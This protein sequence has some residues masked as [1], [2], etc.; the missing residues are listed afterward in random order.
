MY[1]EEELKNIRRR[2]GEFKLKVKSQ[3]LKVMTRIIKKYLKIFWLFARI[4]FINQIVTHRSNFF[5]AILGKI[6][7][8]AIILIFFQAIYFNT[9]KIA[10]WEYKHIILLI[11]TYLTIETLTITTFHRNL[12]YYFPDSLKKGI[13][14]FVLIKPINPLFHISFRVV[15]LMDI[16]GSIFI[17]GLWIWFFFRFNPSISSGQVLQFS[18]LNVF[19]YFCLLI[20]AVIFIFS[21]SLIL[22]STAFWTLLTS[23]LGRFFENM[24]RIARFPTDIFRSAAKVLLVYVI[25]ISIISTIPTKT[26]LGL[27]SWSHIL[28]AFLFTTVLFILSLK[29]WRYA[30]K[31]YT[32]IA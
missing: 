8:M 20:C 12:F 32:S 30:L 21:L 14:D 3:K 26:L 23:G 24:T 22:A 1:F 19:L 18:F 15:D 6:S 28:F 25:P 16:F 11:L 13:F 29:F 27:I 17:W 5:L 2:E 7:R 9:A 31:R 10:S 4:S